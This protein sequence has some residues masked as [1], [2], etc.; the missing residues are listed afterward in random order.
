MKII[1]G[2]HG[3]KNKPPPEVLES[4]WRHAI[5]EGLGRSAVPV[6]RIPFELVYWAHCVYP[7]A[8]RPEEKNP[9]SE[10]FIDQ[11]FVPLKVIPKRINTPL[12]KKVLEKIEQKVDE[13][14]LTGHKVTDYDWIEDK[15][16]Q[17]FFNDLDTYYHKS[18][19]DSRYRERPAKLIIR[20]QLF[21]KLRGHRRNKILLI[22]HSMGSIIAFDV[23]AAGD[24]KISVHTLITCGSPLGLPAVMKRITA[25]HRLP[26]S[27]EGCLP[28][29]EAIRNAWFNFSDL[30]DS[31]AIN[32]NLSDDYLQNNTGVRPIDVIVSNDYTYKGKREP[33]SAVGYLR[34]AEISEVIRNFLEKPGYRRVNGD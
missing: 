31:V 11:P 13:L 4:W 34:T 1:I 25:E 33:H 23:L 21:R 9:R 20:E 32:Y 22:A 8:L 10:L 29:P 14:L 5:G 27:K 2:I 19:I 3:L 24:P 26:V 16:M 18:R 15:I 6:R 30:D 17:H 28:T 7:F 12:R